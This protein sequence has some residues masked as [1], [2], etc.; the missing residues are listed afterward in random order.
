MGEIFLES[1]ALIH[2]I[3]WGH[4]Q[5][6][7][8][9]LSKSFN[10]YLTIDF[11]W[12]PLIPYMISIGIFKYQINLPFALHPSKQVVFNFQILIICLPWSCWHQSPKRGDCKENGPLAYL[13]WILVFDDQHNQIGLMNLQLFVLQFNRVQDVTWTNVT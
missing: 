2:N 5:G 10:W 1:Q 7:D 12:Y 4:L 13:L 11:N 9:L 8:K 3:I 6:Q